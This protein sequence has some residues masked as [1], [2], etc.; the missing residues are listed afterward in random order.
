M[1][2]F[3]GNGVEGATKFEKICRLEWNA[4]P[5]LNDEFGGDFESYVA[6]RMAEK[7]GQVKILKKG[8][9]S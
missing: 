8:K 4:A 2:N 1:E 5:G 7:N 9:K 6:Y 3:I